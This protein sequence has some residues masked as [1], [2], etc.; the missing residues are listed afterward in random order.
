MDMASVFIPLETAAALSNDGKLK[1]IK[2]DDDA[3]TSSHLKK[4]I[5]L[6]KRIVGGA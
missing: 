1:Q 6:K 5:M 3:T 2:Y 4:T